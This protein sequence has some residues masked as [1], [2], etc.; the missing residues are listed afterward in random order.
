[1]SY[2]H[3][4]APLL[5]FFQIPALIS[6]C[7]HDNGPLQRRSVYMQALGCHGLHRQPAILAGCSSQWRPGFWNLTGACE[8]SMLREPPPPG[9]ITEPTKVQKREVAR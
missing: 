1:M 6:K 9:K 8:M 2:Y 5:S 3:S 4:G 7:V